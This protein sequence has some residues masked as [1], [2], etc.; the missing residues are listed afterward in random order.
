M[1]VVVVQVQNNHLII[2]WVALAEAEQVAKVMELREQP[3]LVVEVE[4]QLEVYT[5]EEQAE[6]VLSLLDIPY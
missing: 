3:V 6:A 1:R 5:V 4:V 2:L